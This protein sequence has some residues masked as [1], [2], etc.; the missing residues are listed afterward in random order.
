MSRSRFITGLD[1][2]TTNIRIIVLEL[3]KNSKPRVAAAASYPSFGLRRGVVINMTEARENISCCLKKAGEISQSSLKKVYVNIG[4]NHISIIGNKGGVAVSRAN[5]EVS[6]G[7]IERVI[8]EAKAISISPNKEPLHTI[9]QKYK[10]DDQEGIKD[11]LG[12]HGVKLEV[13]TL[14]ICG[15][16]PHIKNLTKTVFETGIEIQDLVFSPLAISSALLSCRQKE[17]GTMILDLGGG[18]TSFAVWEEGDLIHA[19]V[20]PIGASHITND[21]A[22]GL[23][24]SLDLAEQIKIK[25][26]YCLPREMTRKEIID[27][28]EFGEEGKFLKREV[29]EIIEARW[30]EIFDLVN[31]ELRKIGREK[32]LPA[33]V[34]LA[35]GGAKSQG[36]VELAK[37]ELKLPCFI[38]SFQLEGI[39]SQLD[40]ILF[41]NAL[42]LA[43]YGIREGIDGF[44][45]SREQNLFSK[46]KRW[47]KTFLP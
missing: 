10:L 29:S 33:G 13:D 24:I 2:G 27:L 43:F 15:G 21:I 5:G 32:L 16:T 45:V 12:M 4:G 26:G 11:P 40:N 23:R 1:V 14:I 3:K 47:F 37:R 18:T 42:G 31:K 25:Y 17:L 38:G 35:G 22:I 9:P 8:N 41:A 46:V 44:G 30:S 19:V 6:E 20:L 36:I 39:S 34:I 7:D 28:S